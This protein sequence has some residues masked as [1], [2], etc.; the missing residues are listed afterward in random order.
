MLASIE[1]AVVMRQFV[2]ARH[3]IGFL[4]HPNCAAGSRR[5]VH[6]GRT[7]L[8]VHKIDIL[9]VGR[10][11]GAEDWM[12]DA[13]D[14]YEARLRGSIELNTRW[15]KSDQEL[16]AAIPGCKGKVIC[17]DEH[18]THMSSREF[19]SYLFSALEEG[20]C[21]ATFVIGGADGL[22]EELRPRNSS[23][24]QLAHVSLSKMTY[25]H[26]FARVVLYEQIYRA[27]EIQKNSKYHRD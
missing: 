9:A 21:R 15:L 20:G 1:A 19:S 14:E 27:A 4:L 3:C 23:V 6:R 25:T 13:T 26:Q 11:N 17:L 18:G 24:P 10:K 7:A 12:K 2:I 16:V 8:A 22:P 5:M